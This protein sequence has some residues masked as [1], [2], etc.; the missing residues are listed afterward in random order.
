MKAVLAKHVARELF[1]RQQMRDVA[2]VLS[3]MLREDGGGLQVVQVDCSL[4][5][6]QALGNTAWELNDSAAPTE[7]DAAKPANLCQ[8]V[9][10]VLLWP[11]TCLTG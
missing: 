5:A 8:M 6:L 10:K 9:A 7:D 11:R 2:Q 3:G 4:D 1:E